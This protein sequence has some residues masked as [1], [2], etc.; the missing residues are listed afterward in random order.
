VKIKEFLLKRMEHI[1]DEAIFRYH[2]AI[3]IRDKRI[4]K[5]ISQSQL[6]ELLKLPKQSINRIE[7]CSQGVSGVMLFKIASELGID[8]NLVLSKWKEDK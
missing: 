7:L 4:E 6:I 5:N 1:P 2:I 8:L 3:A